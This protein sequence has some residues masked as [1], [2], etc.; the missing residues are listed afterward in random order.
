M[1]FKNSGYFQ[2]NL[3]QSNHNMF[4]LSTPSFI[5]VS[6]GRQCTEAAEHRSLITNLLIIKRNNL[7]GVEFAA[8]YRLIENKRKSWSVSKF[9]KHKDVNLRLTEADASQCSG[10]KRHCDWTVQTQTA[11]FQP[12]ATSGRGSQVFV[13]VVLA[14]AGR[15]S[16]QEGQVLAAMKLQDPAVQIQAAL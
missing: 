10:S 14:P 12:A 13:A 2:H 9:S 3:S 11:S 8:K 1:L 4:Y 7:R 15:Y 6:R 5:N 16:V